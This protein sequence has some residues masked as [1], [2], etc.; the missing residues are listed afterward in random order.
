MWAGSNPVQHRMI[1]IKSD[2]LQQVAQHGLL[3]IQ[4][5]FSNRF[6]LLACFADK[7]YCHYHDRDSSNEV[8]HRTYNM[9]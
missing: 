7:E 4:P 5:A 9:W 1:T 2:F 3:N 6:A 8:S